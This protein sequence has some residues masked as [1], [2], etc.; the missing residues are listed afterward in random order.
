MHKLRQ[1]KAMASNN[2]M[3]R[4]SPITSN[5]TSKQVVGKMNH[6]TLEKAL[7]L[8]FKERGIRITKLTFEPLGNDLRWTIEAREE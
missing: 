7:I 3:Q 6:I 2:T 4:L 8:I 1:V 5:G